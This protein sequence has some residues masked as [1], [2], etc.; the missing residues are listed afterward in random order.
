LLVKCKTTGFRSISITSGVKTLTS[1]ENEIN[2][3]NGTVHEN[4]ECSH[5]K[6]GI[7]APNMHDVK[8]P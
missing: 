5:Y 8:L 2:Q 1:D 6:K 3:D 4:S 7:Q